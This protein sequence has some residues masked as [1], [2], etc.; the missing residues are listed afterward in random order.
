MAVET[1]TPSSQT[2]P[3]R[4]GERPIWVSAGI[5]SVV[6]AVLIATTDDSL[7]TIANQYW[8]EAT[9]WI[10]VI[11]LVNLF[12]IR[13][14]ELSFTLDAPLTLAVAILYPP[15]LAAIIGLVATIDIREIR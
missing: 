15:S 3:S 10:V 2:G 6:L 12:P 4:L 11:A 8:K 5:L 1:S 9:F 14:Q 7:F 13:F